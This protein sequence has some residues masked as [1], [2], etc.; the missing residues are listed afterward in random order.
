MF[1]IHLGIPEME[2]LWNDLQKKHHDGTAT[3][4]EEKLRRQMGK[5][6][7][8]LSG[9]PRHPGL[10][11]HEISSLTARYGQKV[12]ESYLE[13][14]TPKAGRIFWCYGPGKGD[15]TIVGLEPHP[16]DKSNGL[17]K[18]NFVFHGK[19]NDL[20]AGTASLGTTIGIC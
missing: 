6:M 15:I 19:R 11:S 8:L 18:S 20:T 5:A 14:D 17:Q 12:W 1:E 9:N 4:K 7:A 3:K 16:E 2:R 13:N 10:H